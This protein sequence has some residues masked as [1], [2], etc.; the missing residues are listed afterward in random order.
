MPAIIT[1]L[2]RVQTAISFIK[3]LDTLRSQ[4]K[5]VLAFAGRIIPWETVK[6]DENEI[7]VSENFPPDI[8]NVSSQY[9]D[10]VKRN[11]IYAKPL[12]SS[13]A[14]LVTKRYNWE[15]GFVYTA[16]RSDVDMTFPDFWIDAGHPYYV[17]NPQTDSSGNIQHNVY[18]CISNN[19]GAIS[20][21]PPTGQS[22]EAFS[23]NDG[24]RWKYMYDISEEMASKF[25]TE[26][27]LPVPIYESQKTESHLQAEAVTSGGSIDGVFI[28]N[29]GTG[30]TKA[31]IEVI[32]DGEGAVIDAKIDIYTKT[33]RS[34]E[35]KNA[36]TGYSTI[37]MK[38]NGNGSGGKVSFTVSPINGHGVDI[39]TE[40]GARWVMIA[41]KFVRNENGAFPT[42]SPYRTLGLI[43]NVF[44]NDK[45]YLKSA[46]VKFF[47]EM[48]IINASGDFPFTSK[49]Y[50][51]I[52]KATAYILDKDITGTS[53]TIY[54]IGRKGNFQEGEPIRIEGNSSSGNIIQGGYIESNINHLSGDILYLENMTRVMRNRTQSELFLLTIGF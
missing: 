22:V 27:W 39:P 53:G 23:C 42:S 24:Y 7:V 52:S 48:Q 2:C 41:A 14:A 46:G 37:E 49:I 33:L 6:N 5:P 50:G 45:E 9:L 4:G 51:T 1:S 21:D 35:I 47:D 29:P 8:D 30:Y 25:L 36:G 17:Y 15:S 3:S 28:E 20:T 13:D 40:L 34:V 10:D 19:N 18:I 32:G 11:I 12:T 16:W 54:I 38:V 31:S 26:T 44:T 43:T